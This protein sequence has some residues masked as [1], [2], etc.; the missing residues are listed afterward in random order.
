MTLSLEQFY[1]GLTP[2]EPAVAAD[3]DD[4]L[5][6][7][8]HDVAEPEECAALPCKP[9]AGL[10]RRLERTL[11]AIVY[12]WTGHF[13]ERTRV[14]VRQLAVY[15]ENGKYAYPDERETARSRPSRRLSPRWR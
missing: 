4:V 3:L 1:H 11:P 6:A 2:G 9:L 12:R 13:P 5:Q 7:V 14:L 15:A 8:L 10:L